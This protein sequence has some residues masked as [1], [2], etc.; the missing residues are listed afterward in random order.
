[1][2][3]IVERTGGTQRILPRAISQDLTI[4]SSGAL[5]AATEGST[6]RVTV[7]IRNAGIAAAHRPAGPQ[8]G[9]VHTGRGL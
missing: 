1:M 5:V 9:P 4:T 3:Y 2:G 6:R 7:R 8:L